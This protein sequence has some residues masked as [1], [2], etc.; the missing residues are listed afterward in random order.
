MAENKKSFVLYTDLIHTVKKLPKDKVGELFLAILGYVNDLDPPVDDV[1]VD[2][3]FTPIKAQL[4]RDLEKWNDIKEKK[5]ESGI[6]GN[7][8]RYHPIIYRDLEKGVIDLEEALKLIKLRKTS[9]SDNEPRTTSQSLAKLAVNVNDTVTVNV[10]DNDNVIV[11]GIV[12]VNALNKTLLS[13]IKISDVRE[14]YKIYVESA[15]AFRELFTQYREEEK[16]TIPPHLKN[17]IWKNWVTPIRLL[18]ERDK[19]TIEDLRKV[20]KFLYY[21]REEPEPFWIKTIESVNGLRKHFS[22]LLIKSNGKKINGTAA[23]K[24]IASD[25]IKR[26]AFEKIFGAKM[27]TGVQED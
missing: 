27:P 23:G 22:K 11:N 4:K 12:N 5:S 13:K 20:F 26:R 19:Y 3:V 6:K 2:L 9:H 16:I 1:M 10:N 25:N 7:I 17:A 15:N 8:K 14:D 18:I 24:T 21:E